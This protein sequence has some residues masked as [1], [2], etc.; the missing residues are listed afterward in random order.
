MGQ[1]IFARVRSVNVGGPGE[2]DC[3]GRV[4]LSALRKSPVSGPV[5]VGR[6]GLSGD[7]QVDR[8]HHGGEGK[9][10]Y[11]F[12]WENYAYWGQE[13]AH[14]LS[15]PGLFGE[16]LTTEGLSETQV[17]PG[18]RLNFG[19]LVLEVTQPRTPCYKLVTRLKAAPGFA[20]QFLQSGRTGFYA[21]VLQT[22]MVCAGDQG[23]LEHGAGSGPTI[24]EL[25]VAK[26]RK[27]VV[28]QGPLGR[29]R[30]WIRW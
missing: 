25:A 9:A 13:L 5:A 29:L 20:R 14:D 23:V 18:D 3:G 21:R 11:V 7:D 10:V 6:L 30:S 27:Q 22:G 26:A 17:R 16:N 15:V 2:L 28:R 1:S 12:A 19:D 4:V 8:K 24:A